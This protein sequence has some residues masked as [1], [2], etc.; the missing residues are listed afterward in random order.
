MNA[1]RIAAG[2]DR[3]AAQEGIRACALVEGDTGLV[4][5]AT[6]AAAG[7]DVWEAAADYWRLHRRQRQRF[8]GLG[9]LHAVVMYHRHETLAVLP[10]T[11]EP[12]LLVVCVAAHGCVDW[13]RWQAEV[14]ALACEIDTLTAR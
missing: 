6:A 14:R 9:E 13:I 4:W 7:A 2:L 3:M 1:G 11:R 5:H 12:D 10:C 8:K